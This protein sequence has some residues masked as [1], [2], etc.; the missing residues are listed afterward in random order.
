MNSITY[1]SNVLRGSRRVAATTRNTKRCCVNSFVA[2]AHKINNTRHWTWQWLSQI[3]WWINS[4][5]CCS[6][7]G[8]EKKLSACSALGFSLF[9]I[10][11]LLIT[12]IRPTDVGNL[13]SRDLQKYQISTDFSAEAEC[14]QKKLDDHYSSFMIALSTSAPGHEAGHSFNGV[15]VDS[16]KK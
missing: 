6:V 10:S 1:R 3:G 8:K 14:T 4:S 9:S 16:E 12:H 5:I 11:E 15:G 7:F 13:S 2:K